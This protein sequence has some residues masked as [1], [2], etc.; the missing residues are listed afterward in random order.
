M[1]WIARGKMLR[2]GI[3]ELQKI[4][5]A[6]EMSIRSLGLSVKQAMLEDKVELV[7]ISQEPISEEKFEVCRKN[8]FPREATE[9]EKAILKKN[10]IIVIDANDRI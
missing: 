7:V 4:D 6:L 5:V 10:L 1:V 8:A 3:G 9:E 2:D